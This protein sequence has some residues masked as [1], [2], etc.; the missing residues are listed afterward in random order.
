MGDNWPPE[1]PIFPGLPITYHYLFALIVGK[2]EAIGVPLDWAL[3]IPSII[4][5]FLILLMIYLLAKKWFGDP[6]I[7]VLGVAFFLFN[8]SMGF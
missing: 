2:L 7:G 3:N 4:G 6:R 5:F 1:Y 8:G